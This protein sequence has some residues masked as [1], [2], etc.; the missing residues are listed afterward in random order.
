M[1][2][3]KLGQKRITD[4]LGPSSEKILENLSE[5]SPDLAKYIIEIAYGPQS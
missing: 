3:N 1:D 5:I 4:I 2:K